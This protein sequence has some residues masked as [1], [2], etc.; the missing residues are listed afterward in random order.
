[1]SRVDDVVEA[2]EAGGLAVIPT[3]TV[4]GL[5]CRPD[6]EESVL[7]LST[8][9]GRAPGQPIA[10][11]AASVEALLELVPELP[12]E[13]LE[14]AL[15]APLTLVVPNRAERLRWLTGSR[16]DTLG[17]RVPDVGG[18]AAELLERLRVVAATS[19]NLHGG[20][21]PRRLSDIPSEILDAVA[22]ALDGGELPGLPSTVVDLT[23]Q[24]PRILREGAMPAAEALSRVGHGRSE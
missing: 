23:A 7:E 3:D 2:V 8:V 1:V 19:A 5:A 13:M 21:D 14:A 20:A 17:V 15:P 12:R 11:V 24:E 22:A 18:L 16:P 4:Y 9:K 6:S 10:V